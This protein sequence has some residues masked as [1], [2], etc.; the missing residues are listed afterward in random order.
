VKPPANPP[1]R[2]AATYGGPTITTKRIAGLAGG[3]TLTSSGLAMVG[4]DGPEL[5]NLP[6]GASVIPSIP[7]RKMMG[8]GTVYNITLQAGLVSN[9]DQVGQE[10]IEAIRRAERRSGKVFASA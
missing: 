5:V 1:V 8:G 10:I 7:S 6:R 9:P 4:E 2:P 3:G